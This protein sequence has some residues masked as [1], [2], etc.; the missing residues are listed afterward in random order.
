MIEKQHTQPT[1]L[2]P[3]EMLSVTMWKVRDSTNGLLTDSERHV[4]K[5]VIVTGPVPQKCS[6]KKVPQEKEYCSYNSSSYL[7]VDR[8]SE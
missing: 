5:G 6:L 1:L 2:L 7:S 8:N 3:E 4:R